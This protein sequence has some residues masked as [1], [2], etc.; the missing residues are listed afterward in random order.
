MRSWI[1]RISA[2]V[3][4]AVAAV[5]GASA[6]EATLLTAPQFREAY[7]EVVLQ[8]APG[9]QYRVDSDFELVLMGPEGEA[10]V[11]LGNAYED[12]RRQPTDLEDLL[13][14]QATTALQ[15]VQP[16]RAI[17]GSKLLVVVRSLALRDGYEESALE[18]GAAPEQYKLFS[19]PLPGKLAAIV[20]LDAG[21]SLRYPSATELTEAF[22]SADRIWA[23]AMANTP[24]RVGSPQVEPLSFTT[25]ISGD[26]VATS[27]LLMDD[28]WADFGRSHPGRPVVFIAGN[29]LLLVADADNADAMMQLRKMARDGWER[30]DQF[31]EPMSLDLL[32]RGPEGWV[33][34]ASYPYE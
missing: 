3:V 6:A 10:R 17:D 31:G 30:R 11:F 8:L 12:Y 26:G 2:V 23:L 24:K 16:E 19:R 29:D 32:T 33:V 1:L 14:R 9:T 4:G 34:F 7:L 13:R 25:A 5:G 28:F 20:V 22:G 18:A 15:V 27:L 21:D